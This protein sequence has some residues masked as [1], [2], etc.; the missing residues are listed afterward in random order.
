MASPVRACLFGAVLVACIA[1][2]PKDTGDTEE[3]SSTSAFVPFAKDFQGFRQWEAI[4]LA[5]VVPPPASN[6]NVHLN[7]KRTLYIKARPPKGSKEFPVGTLIV[8]EVVNSG[9]E[10]QLFA[11]THRGGKYSANGGRG[12]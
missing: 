8:K 3:D 12:W 1:C 7:G 9:A 2:Q 10:K 5:D 11:M 6:V 4:R